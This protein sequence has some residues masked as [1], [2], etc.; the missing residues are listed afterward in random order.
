MP[1]MLASLSVLMCIEPK[2]VLICTLSPSPCLLWEMRHPERSIQAAAARMDNRSAVSG[3]SGFMIQ[4]TSVDEPL[5]GNLPAHRK[6]T[7]TRG[8]WFLGL[9]FVSGIPKDT[10]L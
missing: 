6:H 2:G 3:F 4:S 9:G 1:A 5:P 7:P 10:G 8:K